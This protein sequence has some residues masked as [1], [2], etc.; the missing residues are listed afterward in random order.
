MCEMRDIPREIRKVRLEGLVSGLEGYI[1]WKYDYM[2]K[3]GWGK[4]HHFYLSWLSSSF[5]R[6]TIYF[7]KHVLMLIP[8]C[9]LDHKLLSSKSTCLKGR[10]SLVVNFH[11]N[12]CKVKLQAIGNW[13]SFNL[14]SPFLLK[15]YSVYNLCMWVE[16][17]NY[18]LFSWEKTT[19]HRL[20][21]FYNV[22]DLREPFKVSLNLCNK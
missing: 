19:V 3:F 14:S 11:L 8:F 7:G 13:L 16:A 15:S 18:W 22:Y 12:K 9:N 21:L 4:T 20:D 10:D 1:P 2:N 6:L 5:M 17:L